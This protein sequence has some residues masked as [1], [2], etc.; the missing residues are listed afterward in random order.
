MKVRGLN[1]RHFVPLVFVLA[2]IALVVV[3]AF[4]SGFVRILAGAALL[5]L[6]A[7]LT[8]SIIAG[9]RRRFTWEIHGHAILVF[10][11][12]LNLRNRFLSGSIHSQSK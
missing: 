5:Y 12:S 10:V 8:A 6:S 1:L 11:S 9:S 3:A 7:A 4:C 2:I